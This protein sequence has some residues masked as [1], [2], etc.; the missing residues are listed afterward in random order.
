MFTKPRPGESIADLFL[1]LAAEWDHDKNGELT[2]ADLLPGS[3]A[4]VWWRCSACQHGWAT[5]V[6]SRAL[7]GSGCQKCWHV[8]RGRLKATPRPGQSLA[9]QHPELA[10]EWHPTRNG[11]LKPTDVKPASNK[12]VWWQC[13]KGHE[14]LVAPCDRLRGEQCPKCAKREKALRRA[15]PKLGASLADLYPEI[16][17]E[18]HPTKNRPLTASNVNPGSKTRRWWKCRNCSHDWQTD[19]DHRTRRGDGCPKCA[20]ARQSKTASTPKPGQSL[21]EKLPDLAAEWHPTLNLPLTPFDVRPRGGASVW[22]RCRFGHV[23]KA[24]IAP[25][26]VGIGCP[27][28]SVI[29][30]SQRE[31]R[32]KYELIAAGLPVDP[33]HAPI[34]VG[35]RR[36]VRA[37]IVIPDLRVVVEYDG[38]YYHASLSR[39]DRTQTAALEAAGWIV[40]RVRELPLPSIGGNEVFVTSTE[41]IK[42][43][44]RKVLEALEAMGYRARRLSEYLED[45]ETWG[46]TAAS[47]A[48]N[49]FRAKS[50][51]SEHP[52]IAKQFDLAANHPITPD[53]VPPGTM[54]K[55]WWKCDVCGYK[56]Q[57]SVN[58]RLAPRGCKPC[59]VKRRAASSSLPVPGVSFADLFPTAAEQWHPTR[60][61]PLTPKDVAPASNKV[62]WWQCHRGHEWQARVAT[63]R[64][65]GQCRECP[66]SESGRQRKR[67]PSVKPTSA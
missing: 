59:G 41:T 43:L 26:A 56:W 63:R 33:E 15:T 54:N 42:S 55:Y 62:V 22:W 3:S 16:A 19:P 4:R 50:L 17:V 28:C 58:Q 23:W 34:A 29:G 2:P 5:T 48:L 65:Y 8:R 40:L 21:G 64:E 7:R 45:P 6:N 47:I 39:R 53:S 13:A 31:T 37:D 9:D 20:P 38:S 66:I 24:K 57:A 35:G 51:A 49:K 52:A 30:V 32:L 1:D 18:W 36:P 27:K 10:P 67:T 25:R 46:D 44:A 60:N 12:K 11:D 61:A 14:W